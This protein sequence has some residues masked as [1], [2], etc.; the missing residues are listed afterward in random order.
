MSSKSFYRK[1]D[2]FGKARS[3]CP[4]IWV[5][6]APP[7]VE[8]F[9]WLAI[10]GKFSI[11]DNLR[12]G[13]LVETMPDMCS[14]CGR[15]RESIDDLFLHCNVASSFGGISSKSVVWIGVSMVQ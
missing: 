15:E 5:G 3:P 10:A 9:F 2:P 4:L 1:L 6:L 7:R 8:D 14:L 11:V 12:S 13:L